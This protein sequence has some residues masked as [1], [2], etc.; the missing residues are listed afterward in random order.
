MYKALLLPTKDLFRRN[1][2]M[3]EG[4]SRTSHFLNETSL[5]VE[6][7]I[8]KDL[9]RLVFIVDVFSRMTNKPDTPRETT[10]S[11]YY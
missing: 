2:L 4:T 3:I 10:D 8:D 11:I 5:L 7:F 9:F 6:R 1:T